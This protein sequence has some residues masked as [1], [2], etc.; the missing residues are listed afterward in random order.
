MD[1]TVLTDRR[2]GWVEIT[3]N[4]PDRLNAF[5]DRMHGDLRAAL[6]AAFGQH[7]QIGDIRGRGLMIGVEIVSDRGA[8]T[9]DPERAERI[10]YDCLS[11][12]L[13]FKISA[14]NVLTLSPPLTIPEDD[15]DRALAVVEAA[16]ARAA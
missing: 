9:P 10:L 3:L 8:R 7:P 4:R 5:N 1:A 11:N 6:D 16:I 15:L 12:G 14:G 13:S 2:A